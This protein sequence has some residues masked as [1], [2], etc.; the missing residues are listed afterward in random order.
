MKVILNFVLLKYIN[1]RNCDYLN[2]ILS[3]NPSTASLVG[4]EF[5]EAQQ[6]EIS[7]T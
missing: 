3:G 1:H 2:L 4:K 7:C 5:H 6:S